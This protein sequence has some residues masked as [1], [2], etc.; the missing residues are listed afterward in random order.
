LLTR[1][2]NCLV[3]ISDRYQG[4]SDSCRVFLDFHS[5][6]EIFNKISE[7]FRN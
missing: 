1:I 4:F 7:F 6:I 3:R 2:I 5:M